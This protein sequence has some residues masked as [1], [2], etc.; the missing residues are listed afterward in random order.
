MFHNLR[1]KPL[2]IGSLLPF[3]RHFVFQSSPGVVQFRF[4]NVKGSC[5]RD[6]I[7]QAIPVIGCSYSEKKFLF[8]MFSM[9]APQVFF[10]FFL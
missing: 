8:L 2:V 1:P 10:D 4:E 5:R 7:W 3:H 6:I 9:A